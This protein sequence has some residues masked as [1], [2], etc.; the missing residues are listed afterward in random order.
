MLCQVTAGELEWYQ[1]KRVILSAPYHLFQL[2]LLVFIFKAHTDTVPPEFMKHLSFKLPGTQVMA[3][4]HKTISYKSIHY[5][6]HI[7]LPVSFKIY[8]VNC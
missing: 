1:R 6:G 5:K 4:D 3:A 2:P 7:E 8:Q